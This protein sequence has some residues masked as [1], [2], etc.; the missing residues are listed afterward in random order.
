MTSGDAPP[1]ARP[2]PKVAL[3]V[4]N[5]AYGTA[6]LVLAY[7][8]R[9]PSLDGVEV[10]DEVAHAVA[11]GI[12]ALLL[13]ML[14]ARLTSRTLAGLAAWLGATL[15]GGLT[16]LLQILQPAR[17]SQLSDLAADGVGALLAVALGLL[18]VSRSS[19]GG[20]GP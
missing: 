15:F 10:P 14:L 16:E 4:A 6:L 5:I 1:V 17:A 9:V 18:L 12:Q 11:Y 8:P 20:R 7:I 19:R 13:L 3:A 2:G